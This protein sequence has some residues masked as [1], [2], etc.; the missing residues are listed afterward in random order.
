MDKILESIN[1]EVVKESKGF[2]LSLEELKSLIDKVLDSSVNIF[3]RETFSTPEL[4]INFEKSIF[5]KHKLIIQLK[6]E[7]YKLFIY[8]K[9][10]YINGYTDGGISIENQQ[11]LQ[12]LK[13]KVDIV[14]IQKKLKELYYFHFYEIERW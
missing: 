11:T 3:N 12:E 7:D 9:I 14:E 1:W 6:K 10:E 2:I 4:I 8:L 13:N 5:S